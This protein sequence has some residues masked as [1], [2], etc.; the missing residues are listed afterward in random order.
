[1]I[2]RFT[3]L[4][5]LQIRGTRVTDKGLETIAKMKSLISVIIDK[6]K[7]S[8]AAIQKLKKARP[9]LFIYAR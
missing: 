6:K 5:S 1:M 9:G 2:S 3:K 4:R 8:P 7:I